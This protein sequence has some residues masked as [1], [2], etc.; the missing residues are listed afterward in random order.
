MQYASKGTL[1]HK[2]PLSNIGGPVRACRCNGRDVCK[3]HACP[4]SRG[5]ACICTL[6]SSASAR[7]T[8]YTTAA[9]VSLSVP[10]LAENGTRG[11]VSPQMMSHSMRAACARSSHGLRWQLR[12]RLGL[13]TEPHSISGS[14]SAS[15]TQICICTWRNLVWHNT[16]RPD[17]VA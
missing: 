3:G 7:L 17:T 12:C 10:S 2:Y 6:S 16:L 1:I 9:G 8:Q 11:V 14:R 5:S 15:V 4:L 13:S